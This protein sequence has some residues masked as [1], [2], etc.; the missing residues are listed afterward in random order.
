M[1]AACSHLTQLVLGHV[2]AELVI[3]ALGHLPNLQVHLDSRRA[4]L[5]LQQ[6]HMPSRDS[7]TCPPSCLV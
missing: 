3:E 6:Y 5:K 1:A 7:A 2:S 4:E